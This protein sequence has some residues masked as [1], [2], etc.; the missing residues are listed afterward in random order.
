MPSQPLRVLGVQGWTTPGSQLPPSSFT[1]VGNICPNDLI[2]EEL[3]NQESEM[4][5]CNLRLLLER[6]TG[7]AE[8]GDLIP[9]VSSVKVRYNRGRWWWLGFTAGTGID[10]AETGE[11]HLTSR[12]WQASSLSASVQ[13]NRNRW[14][15]Q[16]NRA[17]EPCLKGEA[18][19]QW[20]F[21]M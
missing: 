13:G 3:L 12:A 18:Q 6:Q 20:V 4:I 8:R 14:T 5:R 1:R 21:A 9:R 11:W 2:H 7:S 15:L 10:A 19:L 17:L 16:Q